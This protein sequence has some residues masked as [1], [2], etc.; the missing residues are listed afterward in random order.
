[1]CASNPQ[2]R[3]TQMYMKHL[4]PQKRTAAELLNFHR[5]NEGFWIEDRSE[6]FSVTGCRFCLIFIFM[7]A[8][9]KV[10]GK[11]MCGR[12][13][14]ERSLCV[15]R[16]YTRTN[17]LNHEKSAYEV[18]WVEQDLSLLVHTCSKGDNGHQLPETEMCFSSSLSPQS[19]LCF[20][21]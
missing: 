14:V 16:L 4:Y 8:I 20:L 21:I 5:A 2:H 12:M 3:L 19:F 17:K 10:C 15:Q 7:R 1:M 13:S 9:G 6:S 18:C 11:T